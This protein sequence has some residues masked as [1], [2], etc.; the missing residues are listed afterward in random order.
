VNILK[1][2]IK[3]SRIRIKK[4]ENS[5]SAGASYAWGKASD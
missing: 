2:E 4:T 1:K 3:R 5:C